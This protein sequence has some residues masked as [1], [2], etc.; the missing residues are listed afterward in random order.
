M[1][2]E[3]STGNIKSFMVHEVNGGSLIF[4]GIEQ[5]T[6]AQTKEEL[7]KLIAAEQ[8]GA[9]K[10]TLGAATENELRILTTNNSHSIVIKK[11]FMP[12]DRYDQMEDQ[13]KQRFWNNTD[14][15]NVS[16]DFANTEHSLDGQVIKIED[17][18]LKFNL[19]K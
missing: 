3:I 7:E 18:L 14:K 1:K 5:S 10:G 17:L 2:I 9:L 12:S 6:G 8:S 16:I 11:E 19:S 4:R 15:F 13:D